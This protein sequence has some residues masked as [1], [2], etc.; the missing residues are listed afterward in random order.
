[1]GILRKGFYTRGYKSTEEIYDMTSMRIGDTVFDTSRKERRVY[2]GANWVTGN[3]I[4]KT[5][6]TQ[7][8]TGSDL[9]TYL[10]S[11]KCGQLVAYWS[12]GA[13][14]GAGI[15]V[16]S[17]YGANGG[18]VENGIGVIQFPVSR[19]YGQSYV[20]TV[21]QYAGEAYI[22]TDNLNSGYPGSYVVPVSLPTRGGVPGNYW[23]AFGRANK[24]IVRYAQQIGVYTTEPI[25]YTLTSTTSPKGYT[26]TTGIAKAVIKFAETN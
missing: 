24:D 4:S 7:T 23:I 9:I 10:D 3:M 2:D 19:S 25:V 1:M 11:A 26:G 14:N 8:Y 22:Q 13:S 21:V 5:F 15:Y 16:A 18:N 17:L 6:I 20:P 12:V